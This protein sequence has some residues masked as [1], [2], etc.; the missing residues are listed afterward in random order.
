MLT[1]TAFASPQRGQSED[2]FL[3]GRSTLP[4]SLRTLDILEV[5]KPLP[6][7]T[8]SLLPHEVIGAAW[9]LRQELEA[10]CKGGILADE[11]GLGKASS[12][13]SM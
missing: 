12:P 9:M 8:V 11:I 13:F 3:E 1:D 4:E 5:E 2:E 6:G 7:M 10:R